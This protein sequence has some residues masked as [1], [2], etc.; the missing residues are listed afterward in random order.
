MQSAR[1]LIQQQ[2]EASLAGV[3]HPGETDS[4]ALAVADIDHAPVDGQVAK[5]NQPGSLR[6]TV[7][8]RHG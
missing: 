6:M 5:S 4:A 2:A 8:G 1:R 3:Q 7:Q